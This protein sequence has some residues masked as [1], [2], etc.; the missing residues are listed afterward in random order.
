MTAMVEYDSEHLAAI[1]RRHDVT[2]LRVF[3][4]V[5][6]GDAGPASDLDLIVD[7]GVPK[8]FFELT[9]LEDELGEL[10]GCEVDLVTEAGLSPYLRG[11]ILSE[12][13]TVYD[14]AA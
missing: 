10:F 5:A 2:R 4:S 7:F 13:A 11:P 9:R 14:A 12:A 1:C 3:G 8:G 6:R